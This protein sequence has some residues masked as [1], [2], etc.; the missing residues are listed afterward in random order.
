MHSWWEHCQRQALPLEDR[1]NHINILYIYLLALINQHP[2]K[3]EKRKQ[4][5]M[6]KTGCMWHAH[7]HRTVLQNVVLIPVCAWISLLLLEGQIFPSMFLFFKMWSLLYKYFL[8][9]VFASNNSRPPPVMGYHQCPVL[10]NFVNSFY[11][12]GKTSITFRKMYADDGF[13]YRSPK[14]F[15]QQWMFSGV[16]NSWLTI[17][18][19]FPLS[20]HNSFESLLAQ[21]VKMSGHP[22]GKL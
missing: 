14:L 5:Y 13:Y 18:D 21:N 12:D 11:A 8:F 6:L 4:P 1:Q 17:W 9:V 10:L 15:S 3:T 7:A 22:L 19:V 16:I 20:L 2:T